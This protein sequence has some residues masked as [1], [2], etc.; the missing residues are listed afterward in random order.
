MEANDLF[1]FSSFQFRQKYEKLIKTQ[2]NHNRISQML[3]Y[4]NKRE[5]DGVCLIYLFFYFILFL[6]DFSY[7][8]I[9]LFIYFFC[10]K[11]RVGP[12]HEGDT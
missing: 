1:C 6:F 11:R 3:I 12:I 7:L 9:Y 4:A 5:N 2:K 10:V 8:F